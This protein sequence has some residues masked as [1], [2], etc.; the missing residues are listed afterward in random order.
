MNTYDT[1]II[2][3]IPSTQSTVTVPGM[4]LPY[5]GDYTIEALQNGQFV[6]TT[7]TADDAPIPATIPNI[8][9]QDATVK[10]R[11]RL[12]DNARTNNRNY[13]NTS[14]GA[15]WFQFQNVPVIS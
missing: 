1:L 4:D 2:G 3:D 9:N 12:P 5:E 10:F 11:I 15:I 6:I 14:T 13:L 7:L 8:Y